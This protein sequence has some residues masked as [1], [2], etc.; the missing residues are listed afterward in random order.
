MQCMKV[1]SSL[2]A[3]CLRVLHL[4]LGLKLKLPYICDLH[5]TAVF[6]CVHVLTFKL[7]VTLQLTSSAE[8][9][10]SAR[11]LC[12]FPP[13]SSLLWRTATHYKMMASIGHYSVPHNKT[14]VILKYLSL[15]IRAHYRVLVVNQYWS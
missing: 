14:L 6:L 1:S 2:G 15:H 8:R 4:S 9:V 10:D 11:H 3:C 12:L 5:F 13:I 7:S